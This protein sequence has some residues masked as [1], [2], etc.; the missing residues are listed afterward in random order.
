MS[1]TRFFLLVLAF[2][3]A[4]CSGCASFPRSVDTV[5]PRYANI[6]RSTVR[7]EV[8]C[9]MLGE[10][11]KRPVGLGSGVAVRPNVILT[12]A[13]VVDVTPR[14]CPG[15]E[16]HVVRWDGEIFLGVPV[17][18]RPGHY[19]IARMEVPPVFEP[20]PIGP[21]PRVGEEICG[22][23]WDAPDGFNGKVLQ[24]LERPPIKC[25]R[26]TSVTDGIVMSGFHAVKG[27][28]GSGF[29]NSRG[30]VVGVVSQAE[31]NPERDFW[32]RG[33]TVHPRAG[34]LGL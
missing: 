3:M 23:G 13:H 10:G 26:V 17:V 33:P 11:Q 18:M 9:D 21:E 5:A 12:A 2:L 31:P 15:L 7:I 4:A 28:S 20:A 1:T 14:E 6:M 25:D 30:E 22:Y 29:W 16:F 32:V 24:Y 8:W 19:D 34:D 27:N